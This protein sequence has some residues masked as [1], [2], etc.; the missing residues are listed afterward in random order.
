V[1][2]SENRLRPDIG[3]PI[4]LEVGIKGKGCFYFQVLH[5]NKTGAIRETEFMIRGSS[6]EV[7]GFLYQ[8][9]GE[10]LNSQ[11]VAPSNSLSK[12]NGDMASGP[13]ANY[14]ITF[15]QNIIGGN[16]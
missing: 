6:K 1:A 12:L 15:I 8:L 4:F 10:I 9:R 7:P 2:P 14:R 3:F 11:Q 5:Q 13:K 16:Q